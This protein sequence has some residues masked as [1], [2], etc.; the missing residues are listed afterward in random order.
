[1]F[2][3]IDDSILGP[4]LKRRRKIWDSEHSSIRFT[5]TIICHLLPLPSDGYMLLIFFTF[6]YNSQISKQTLNLIVNTKREKVNRR[7]KK[8]Y[9]KMKKDIKNLKVPHNMN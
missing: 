1:M 2:N 7:R 8:E 9:M 3:N 5:P 4:Q 6:I